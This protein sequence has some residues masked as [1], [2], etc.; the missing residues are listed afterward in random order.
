MIVRFT[1]T[2]MT[3]TAIIGRSK[4]YFHTI[5]TMTA[6]IGNDSKIYFYQWWLSWS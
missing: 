1:T 2:I 6:I 4:H 5:M 3:M